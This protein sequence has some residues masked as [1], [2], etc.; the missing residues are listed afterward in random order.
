MGTVALLAMGT[1]GRERGARALGVAVVVLLLVDPGLATSVG[2]AL[3]VLATAG[4]L[5]LAPGWRDA[6]ARWLP[7]WVA[8]AIAVPAAAQLAC[9]PGGRGHLRPGQP[10]RGGRQPGRRRRR[11]GRRRCSGWLPAW[12]VWCWPWGGQL[13]GTLAAWCVAWIVEVA[14]RGADLPTAAV[15]WGT[16]LGALALLTVL[17][18]V[19]A[20]AGPRLLRRPVGG[21]GCCC[22]L[23]AAVL[24]RPPTPGWPPDGWV[25]VACDVGQGDALVAQRRPGLRGRGRRRPRPG[26]RGRVPGPA[27][28][29]PG[30]AAGAD[31]L[32]RR[33]RRRAGRGAR[34]PCGRR[35]GGDAARRPARGCGAGRRPRARG[36][37]RACGGAVRPGA[38]GRGRHPAGALAAAGIAH[39]RAGRR[40]HRQRRQ[41]GAAGR[42][43]GGPDPAHR[44]RRARG[45]GGAGAG[46]CRGC[47]STC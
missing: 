2:F 31:P 40:Q 37:A 30:A 11:S 21:V 39:P 29:H 16:S 44:R 14:R 23:V 27:R 38:A 46:R 32:P 20:L 24:V 19:V 3:S 6:L 4:I 36:R 42:G 10:G 47:T 35:G 33:P 9:T 13:L 17:A 7:R 43:G 25:L 8:E 34:R 22:L 1:D 18:L 15:D 5:L 26:R 12:S 28:H 45:P 41:R